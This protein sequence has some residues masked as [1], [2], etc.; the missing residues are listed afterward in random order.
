MNIK[1]LIGA[2]SVGLFISCE[3]VKE[4]QTVSN[5]Y[6]SVFPDYTFTAIPYNIAPL[7]FEVKGA[8]EIRA[9]F[10][11]EGVNLLT[12]TGKH[13]IRIPKKKW[14]EMLDKLKDKDLEVTVSVW[15][16][17]SPEGVRY[18]PFTVRVAS[19][20]I[21]EW[22]AYRLIEPGYEGW[23]MLGIY[24]R[25]LTSFEEK[26]IATNRADKSKCMNCHSFANYSPSQMIFHVRG[27]G[28]GTALWKDGELSKLPL[29]TT[30]PKKS[31]TYP[32][33]HPNGRYIVFSSN[34]TRQS[35]LS[36]GEKALEVYDLQSDL[37]LYD[38]QTKK[39]LT[40][41]RFMDEAHW[42]TFPAWSADGKSLYYCGALPKNMPIDYQNLHYSLC[43]VDFD[44]A[45]GTFGERIDTIYNAE[46][47]GGSVSFPRLSPDG[48]YLLYTKAACAT[49]PIWHKEAD[50]KMLRLSDGEELDVEILNSAETESYHSW[51]SNG[52][53]ILF[54]SRRLDGRYTRL[55]IA[56]MDEKG[57][58]HKPFLLPQSTVEHNV[59][60]TKSYNIP[61]FIKGE[62]T[63][64][65]KQLNALFFPQK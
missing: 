36:E 21:D 53:W 62:V 40:D 37:I 12:V 25:N 18:K 2:I 30:G 60:R 34:L 3:N 27:E 63:L 39:V 4:A 17:S 11:G 54:S 20:A 38:I 45:T 59:L 49:F 14:K 44:E 28:G 8:Q 7:N 42:E 61:E 13:E 24:Q 15:N 56:W 65:Q 35:F 10:A 48:H 23:N 55:F 1:W 43:K 19:D 26:E 33:W 9:D 58:I 64:P 16:S 46:R 47:D 22:I 29:E 52:R 32:M 5:S 6:P 31:G 50:L 57:N 41:K 51:S